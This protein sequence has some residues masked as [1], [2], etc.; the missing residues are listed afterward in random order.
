[1]RATLP[2]SRGFSRNHMQLM[3]KTAVW[4]SWMILDDKATGIVPQQFFTSVLQ[5]PRRK[6]DETQRLTG[7]QFERIRNRK[8]VWRK[9]ISVNNLRPEKRNVSACLGTKLETTINQEN[10][11]FGF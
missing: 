3:P 9:L 1:M 10:D 2:R 8:V 6:A 11:E 4:P 7:G 5:L